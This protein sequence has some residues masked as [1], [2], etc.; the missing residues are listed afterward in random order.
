MPESRWPAL[1]LA[2]PIAF[3]HRGGAIDALE[4]SIPAF[5]ASVDL[6][7]RFVETDVHATRDGYLVAFHDEHL[8]RVTDATGAIADLNWDEV[9]RARIGGIEPIP[10]LEEVLT[11]WPTLHVNIDPKADASVEPLV[12]VIRKTASIDRVCIGSFSDKRLAALRSTLGS[13]LCTATGPKDIAK[14][15]GASWHLPLGNAPVGCAQVPRRAKG[16][17]IVDEKFI[18]TAH[19]RGIQVHVWTIDEPAEMHELLDMG[20]DG[21]MTDRPTVLRDVLIDRG[22]WVAASD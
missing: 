19:D 14:L 18:A 21:I 20:V 2:G 16:V 12:A 5:Q 8:D 17:T 1:N 6:G 4:N 22:E 13:S 15:R 7:Y 11:T 3:A 9:R 10:L